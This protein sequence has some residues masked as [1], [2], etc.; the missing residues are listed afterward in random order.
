MLVEGALIAQQ[1][2]DVVVAG[3]LDPEGLTAEL[4]RA[5]QEQPL[6]VP[7]GDHLKRSEGGLRGDEH[8][9][10]REKEMSHDR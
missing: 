9:Y 4:H 7:E 8:F 2:L 10:K 5:L 3:V 6:T 1:A